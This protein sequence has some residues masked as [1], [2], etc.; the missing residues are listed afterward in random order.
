MKKRLLVLLAASCGFTTFISGMQKSQSPD[1]SVV[2]VVGVP[3]AVQPS[4]GEA[5]QRSFVF[6]M[7]DMPPVVI[8]V[9]LQAHR[10]SLLA[11]L[12]RALA[13]SGARRPSAAMVAR[14]LSEDEPAD[15]AAS[16]G[17]GVQGI[18]P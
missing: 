11:R 17:V 4:Q 16:G 1:T 15:A 13:L 5:S 9:P 18:I 10:E 7:P 8:V 3:I 2:A 14:L 6:K 12:A